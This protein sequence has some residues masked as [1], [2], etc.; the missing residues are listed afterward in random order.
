MSTPNPVPALN[1][2]SPEE[3]GA[4]LL[5]YAIIKGH[6]STPQDRL[7]TALTI[8]QVASVFSDA[9]AGNTSA[10]NSEIASLTSHI[11]DPAQKIIVG[12]LVAWA[13]PFIDAELALAKGTVGVGSILDGALTAGA[14]GFNK[15]AAAYIAEGSAP[16]AK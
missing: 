7:A 4:E 1:I 5:A 13:T 8:Q 11:S 12:N 3:I 14:K 6:S 9:A 10:L 2:G 16:A 15:I